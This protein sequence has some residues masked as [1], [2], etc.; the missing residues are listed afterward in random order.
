MCNKLNVVHYDASLQKLASSFHSG[1]DYLDRFL[2][3]FSSLDN[4]IGKT[5]VFL[6]DDNKTIIGYYNLGLGYIEQIEGNTMHKIGGAVHINC[7][8]LDERYH[9]LLQTYTDEG[10]KVNL[11]DVPL[12]DCMHRIE[13]LRDEYVG[14]S[15]VTLSSTREG[16]SL[17]ERN[18][19]EILEEDMN[20]SVEDSEEECIPMYLAIDI[21]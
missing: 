16:Y 10:V 19:F 6:S 11:S 13:I 15:F 3:E 8:A 2:R 12:D 14:F 4:N 5:F 1:N 9:G 17:Y 7:F 20:F 21:E 18:G